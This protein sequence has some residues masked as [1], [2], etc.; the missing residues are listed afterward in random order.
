[1]NQSG[2]R[3]YRHLPSGR[4]FCAAYTDP[5]IPLKHLFVERFDIKNGQRLHLANFSGLNERPATEPNIDYREL[6]ALSDQLCSE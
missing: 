4:D 6:L 2:V 3:D 5:G 1:M